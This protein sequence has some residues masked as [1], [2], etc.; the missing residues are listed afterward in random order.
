[1]SLGGE[2]GGFFDA[3]DFDALAAMAQATKLLVKRAAYIYR[4]DVGT[5]I[6]LDGLAPLVLHGGICATPEAAPEA[7]ERSASTP[8]L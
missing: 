8:P 6:R 2:R 4:A 3:T 5:K 7:H 1:M